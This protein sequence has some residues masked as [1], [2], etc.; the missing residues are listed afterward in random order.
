MVRQNK[1][2]LKGFSEIYSDLCDLIDLINST[3][4]FHVA[5]IMII[6]FSIDVFACYGAIREFRTDSSKFSYLIAMN[7]LWLF[8]Q[9]LIK[10]VIA[11]AGS[12]T[13]IESEKSIVL[14][15]KLI[16]KMST[17]HDMKVEMNYLLFHI[18]VRKKNIENIFFTISWNLILAVGLKLSIL[19]FNNFLSL[20][21]GY[22]YNC[23]IRCH[24]LAV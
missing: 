16:A 4:T 10:C 5:L 2:D 8:V 22:V 9:Y 12:S 7:T 6:F 24:N 1:F 15:T 20:S 18:Q 23:D 19:H 11:Q 17:H 14:V 3:F 13:T 21:S